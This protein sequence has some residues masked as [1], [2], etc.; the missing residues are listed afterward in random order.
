M[1]IGGLSFA[2]LNL[3]KGCYT[4]SY[5]FSFKKLLTDFSLGCLFALF[6]LL[7]KQMFL[8]KLVCYLGS[9]I[10]GIVATEENFR[11]KLVDTLIKLIFGSPKATMDVAPGSILEANKVTAT[12]KPSLYAFM[13]RNSG[14]FGRGT[15]N[16]SGGRQA[17]SSGNTGAGN[18]NPNTNT[19]QNGAPQTTISERPLSPEELQRKGYIHRV[20]RDFYQALWEADPRRVHFVNYR[21]MD[22]AY[23]F[24][25]RV[26]P[27]SAE[28]CRASINALVNITVQLRTIKIRTL[29]PVDESE[30]ISLE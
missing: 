15:G 8:A 12:V 22:E 9:V 25:S 11:N 2:A 21:S 23:Q 1:I 19:P 29:P 14:G 10:T 20:A 26:G 4:G 5:C 6:V 3:L 28:G 27:Y 17:S 30:A 7:L 13:T 24:C 16:T 18:E